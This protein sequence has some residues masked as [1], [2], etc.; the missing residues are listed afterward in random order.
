MI[1]SICFAIVFYGVT[2]V[3]AVLYLPLIILPR[4]VFLEICLAWVRLMVA[5]IRIILGIRYELRGLE[6]R[7]DGPAI[8]ASKHQSA[9]DVLIYNLI[10]HDCAYVLK[11]ELYRIPLWGWYVWRVGSVG[12]DRSGGARALKGM[13]AQAS[14]L[15]KHGRSIIVFPQGTRTPVGE[16]RPYLPGAAALYM[17]TGAPVVPVALNSGIF[18]PRRQFQKNPGRITIEFLPPIEPGLNRRDFLKQL[19]DKIE[20]ATTRLEN[21]ALE[22]TPN[23]AYPVYTHTH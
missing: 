11:R 13:V 5:A 15:L 14:E 20:G 3:M 22:R 19:E 8:F 21:E 6:N 18:W 10:V 17:G 2:V 9:W 12:I 1:R 16:C 7:P 23:L 4:R